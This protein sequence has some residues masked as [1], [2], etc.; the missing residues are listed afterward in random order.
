VFPMMTTK[1]ITITEKNAHGTASH[2]DID[3]AVDPW[4]MTIVGVLAGV[5]LV[6]W[7][8]K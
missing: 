3:F 6:R 8:V 1:V 7:L 5:L 4:T 2:S